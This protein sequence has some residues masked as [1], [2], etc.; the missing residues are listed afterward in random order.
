MF[1]QDSDGNMEPV[2]DA[3]IEAGVN[4][5][6][7]CE[8]ASGMDIVALRQKYGKT[9]AFKG[10]LDKHVLRRSKEEIRRELEYKMQP[11]MRE[12]MVFALDHRIPNGTPLE[13]YRY[14]VRT[15]REILGL[16]PL[17]TAEP[18]WERTAF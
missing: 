3:F 15:A 16:E 11:C 2:M 4:V 14:Y 10:G 5:F 18:G 9:V 13:N 17:A 7:P 12:G 8:P 1:S 6:Y